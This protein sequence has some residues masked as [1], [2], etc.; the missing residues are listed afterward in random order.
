MEEVVE[1]NCLCIGPILGDEVYVLDE[2]EPL[3]L[4]THLEVIHCV[5]VLGLLKDEALRDDL[6]EVKSPISDLI[7]WDD[8]V[9]EYRNRLVD[10]E[11]SI[12]I[13]WCRHLGFCHSPL[14]VVHKLVRQ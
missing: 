8:D 1:L 4:L 5:L 9:L 13:I 11:E 2:V 10:R 6:V 3:C 12:V 14:R 7:L